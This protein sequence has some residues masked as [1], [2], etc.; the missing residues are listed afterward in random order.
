MYVYDY[1]TDV[2]SRVSIQ[3][4]KNV[5]DRTRSFSFFFFTIR[6]VNQKSLQTSNLGLPN[7]EQRINVPLQRSMLTKG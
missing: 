2:Y 5:Y 6:I 3:H 7:P 4:M 1:I